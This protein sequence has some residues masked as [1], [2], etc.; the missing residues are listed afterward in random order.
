MIIK[1][2]GDHSFSVRSEVFIQLSR[3]FH[4]IK[5]Y[6]EGILVYIDT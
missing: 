2:Q 4:Q 5:H 1:I 3:K 6:T